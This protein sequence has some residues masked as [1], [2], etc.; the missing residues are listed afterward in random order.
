MQFCL[1]D[2][3]ATKDTPRNASPRLHRCGEALRAAVAMRA[4]TNRHEAES[5]NTQV[6]R[7]K[8]FCLHYCTFVFT[9]PP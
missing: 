6:P 2:F 4:G 3:L 8:L 9:C 5:Q 7:L 1:A